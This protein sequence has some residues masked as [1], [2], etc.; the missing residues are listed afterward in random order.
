MNEDYSDTTKWVM[1]DRDT[2][3]ARELY[4]SLI[5]PAMIAFEDKRRAEISEA[6]KPKFSFISVGF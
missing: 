3:M 2:Y 4:D 5:K 6:S 1:I